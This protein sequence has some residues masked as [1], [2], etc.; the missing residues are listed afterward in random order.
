MSVGFFI[1]QGPNRGKQPGQQI[2]LEIW[3]QGNNSP[4]HNHGDAVAIIKML[5]GSLKSEWFNPLYNRT[6]EAFSLIKKGYLH[7]GDITWMTPC[8]YQTHKLTNEGSTGASISIQGYQHTWQ[9]DKS[10]ETFSESFNYVKP[11]DESLKQFYPNIDFE[12]AEF[13]TLLRNEYNTEMCY[14]RFI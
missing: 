4:V 9:S 7:P 12:F 14:K 11:P 13:K 10:F 6:A 5:H 8:F 1:F 3:P 2:V